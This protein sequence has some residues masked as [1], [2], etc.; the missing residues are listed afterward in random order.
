VYYDKHM[1]HRR[2]VRELG[3]VAGQRLQGA[4]EG[5]REQ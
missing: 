1:E 5:L 3:P 2:T 4:A